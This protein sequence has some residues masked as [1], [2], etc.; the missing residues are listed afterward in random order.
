MLLDEVMVQMQ[1]VRL[2]G[3]ISPNEKVGEGYKVLGVLPDHLKRLYVV[4]ENNQKKMC[5][6]FNRLDNEVKS[7]EAQYGEGKI[8]REKVKNIKREMDLA[9]NE[10]EFVKACFWKTVQDEIDG[11]VEAKELR[12]CQNWQ[13]ASVNRVAK[14]EE[15]FLMFLEALKKLL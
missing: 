15:S 11:A 6:I 12:L 9:I 14:V 7:L 2:D 10:Y 8:P 5:S 4:L 1:E 13:V 3:A